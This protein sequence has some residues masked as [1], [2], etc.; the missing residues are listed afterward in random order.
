MTMNLDNLTI[1]DPVTVGH[2]IDPKRPVIPFSMLVHGAISPDSHCHPRG[3]FIYSLRGITRVITEGEVLL[4]PESQGLWCP[5]EVQHKLIF[6]GSASIANLF[7]DPSR[8]SLLPRIIQV[9]DIPGL[10]KALIIK[11]IAIGDHCPAEGCEIRLME[12]LIDEIAQLTPPPLRLPWCAI[13]SKL[14][15]VV[16]G[17]I[18]NPGDESN[19]EDWASLVGVSS[20]TL[21]RCFKK[22]TGMT[23][24]EWKMQM[25][26]LAAIEWLQTGKSI[27]RIS[28]DLGYSNPSTFSS[29]FKKSLGKTPREYFRDEI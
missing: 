19:I 23:F 8:S 24:S 12:V 16:N 11:A 17:L 22:E 7:I 18:S 1:L 14:Q 25:K 6:P 26:L 13:D 21:E 27:T 20:R 9:F 4:I 29:A 15:K 10:L 2:I 5:P 28:M 3:Q